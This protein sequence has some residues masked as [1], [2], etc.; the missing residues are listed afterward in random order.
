MAT[1]ELDASAQRFNIRMTEGDPIELAWSVPGAAS[2]AGEYDFTVYV[3]DQSIALDSTVE[4]DGLDVA[5]SVSGDPQPLLTATTSGYAWAMS[6][7]GG[8]TRFAGLMF[9]ESLS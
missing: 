9:V 8:L 5:F 6:E 3:D 2:W 1:P 4:A 7:V